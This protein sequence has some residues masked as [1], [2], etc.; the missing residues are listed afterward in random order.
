MSL[1]AACGSGR[2]TSVIPAV[3]AAWSVTTIAFTVRLL[4][5]PIRVGRRHSVHLPNV[6]AV[7]R[8]SAVSTRSPADLPSATRMAEGV[9]RFRA[10]AGQPAVADLRALVVPDDGRNAA[11]RT[12]CRHGRQTGQSHTDPPGRRD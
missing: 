11:R 1:I 6:R 4:D 5:L 3:P 8:A 12:Y 7:S 9:V 2:S 10:A